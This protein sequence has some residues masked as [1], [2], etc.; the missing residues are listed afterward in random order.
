MMQQEN[1]FRS[2]GDRKANIGYRRL[3]GEATEYIFK[4]VFNKQCCHE[5]F[6]YKDAVDFDSRSQYIYI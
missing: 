3:L 4:S 5:T 1:N 6:L 2:H